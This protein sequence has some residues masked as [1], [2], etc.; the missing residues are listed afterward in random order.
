M[1]EQRGRDRGIHSR[2]KGSNRSRVGAAR[3]KIHDFFSPPIA[4]VTPPCLPR[5]PSVRGMARN[6]PAAQPLTPFP[7]PRTPQILPAWPSFPPVSTRIL[8]AYPDIPPHS[9]T[10]Q[11][12]PVCPSLPW[13][14]PDTPITSPSQNPLKAERPSMPW[15]LPSIKQTFSSHCLPPPHYN[16]TLP[17]RSSSPQYQTLSSHCPPPPHCNLTTPAHPNPLQYQTP[18]SLWAPTSL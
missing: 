2:E 8:P 10:R 16:H 13:Y 7:L 15:S 5:I 14:H 6:S 3:P 18:S 12:L 1:W 4:S 17:A 11:A 9:R